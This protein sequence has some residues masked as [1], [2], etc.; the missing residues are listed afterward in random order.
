MENKKEASEEALTPSY[1][2]KRCRYNGDNIDYE[3]ACDE[4]DYYLIC[5]QDLEKIAGNQINVSA[6]SNLSLERP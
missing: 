4:C 5:F 6:E 2:G 1:H 3:I